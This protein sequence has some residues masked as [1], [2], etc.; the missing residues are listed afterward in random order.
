MHDLE[1]I[2]GRCR[3]LPLEELIREAILHAEDYE[4]EPQQVMRQEL[5]RRVGDIRAYLE[6]EREVV[7]EA[8]LRLPVDNFGDSRERFTGTL[9]FTAK[10]IGFASSGRDRDPIP[11]HGVARSIFVWLQ[12]RLDERVEVDASPYERIP[13]SLLA[14]LFDSVF[15]YPRES[16]CSVE[17]DGKTVSIRAPARSDAWGIV[18]EA[19]ATKVE[20]WGE[21]AGVTVTRRVRQGLWDSVRRW[22]GARR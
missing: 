14:R 17:L 21:K 8:A 9:I 13:I 2:R 18:A 16:G 19:D 20:E 6:R 1:Y 22:L 5:E 7:G 12:E 3:D 4:E 10:G 11:L 15:W